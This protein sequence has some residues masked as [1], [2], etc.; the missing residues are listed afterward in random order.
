MPT[1]EWNE[2]DHVYFRSRA[3]GDD[4]RMLGFESAAKIEHI[5]L[6]VFHLRSAMRYFAGAWDEQYAGGSFAE[7]AAN[8][9]V[10]ETIR[11]P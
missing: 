3:F 10:L 11:L 6:T 1:E 7:S 2:N 9:A 5:E 4:G 8:R